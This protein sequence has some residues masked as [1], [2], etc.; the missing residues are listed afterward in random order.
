MKIHSIETGFFKLDGGAMFGVVPKTIWQ[1]INPADE[2]NLCNWALRSLLIETDN[3]LILVDTGIGN[4]QGPEFL[5]HYYLN[6]T[7]SLHYSLQKKG[8]NKEDITDVI[9]THFHF[10]HCG[11]C[12]DK[13]NEKLLPAFPNAIYWCSEKQ[14]MNVINPNEREKSSY[15]KEN[16]FPLH[17]ANV[18][19]FIN[20]KNIGEH[21]F[22]KE[23]NFLNNIHLYEVNG[24]TA[25]MILPKIITDKGTFV[26]MADLIPSV[27]HIP[28]PYVMGYDMQPLISM[29]EKK[30]FLEN[31]I[32][33]NTTLIFQHDPINEA[34]NLTVNKNKIV[35]DKIFKL[36]SV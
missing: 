10:D 32:K 33:T 29:Q 8:F 13:I 14:W 26:F 6:G 35:A 28:I 7:D 12:V 25:G 20:S 31:E 36:D 18:L 2:N 5:K 34:C 15:L 19:K 21:D 11:G 4:K 17:D 24:H 9:I 3:R 23:Y 30:L 16:I 22:L 1:K 27:G